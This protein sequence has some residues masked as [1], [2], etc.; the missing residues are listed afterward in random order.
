MVRVLFNKS[1]C[2]ARCSLKCNNLE[3]INTQ[4]HILECQVFFSK[5]SPAEKLSVYQVKYDNIIG[6]L[7]EQSKVVVVFARILDIRE[8]ILELQCLPVG[9]ITGP[10]SAVTNSCL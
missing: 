3:A 8:E 9:K 1:Q 10:D 5:L 6:S 2:N 7:E 4:Q